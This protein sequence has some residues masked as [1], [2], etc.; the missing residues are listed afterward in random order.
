[1]LSE[2]IGVINDLHIPFHCVEALQVVF[3]ILSVVQPS[4]LLLDGDV[5]DFRPLSRF[6]KDPFDVLKLQDDLDQAHQILLALR[7][8]LPNTEFI[9]L[10]GNHEDRLQKYLH[11]TPE[12]FPLECLKLENLL[13]LKEVNCT[14][15][16]DGKPY[17]WN[18]WNIVHGDVV[19]ANAGNTAQG[20]IT[21]YG[22]SGLNGHVHR[23]AV[24]YK[25]NHTQS[26][27]WIE[28]GCLCDLSPE[29]LSVADWQHS[30][31]LLHFDGT[32]V[33]PEL[34]PIHNGKAYYQGIR[35]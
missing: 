11:K 27:T 9:Y 21:K 1:M 22:S 20:M 13:H 26:Y 6:D 34:I 32:T 8:L 3:S 14:Y 24:V 12:L 18:G 28:N 23:A 17:L 29:Y 33:N 31:S 10:S 25:R 35:Y 5:V 16:P 4:K 2:T 7:K 30:M 15:I 19:R